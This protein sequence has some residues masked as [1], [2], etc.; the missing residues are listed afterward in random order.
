MVL[1]LP[2][3]FIAQ[4]KQK[5]WLNLKIFVLCCSFKLHTLE[6]QIL[7]ISKTI[8]PKLI[9]HLYLSYK[10]PDSLLQERFMHVKYVKNL[11]VY[12]NFNAFLSKRKTMVS[13]KT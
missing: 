3:R 6:E 7:N 12:N 10:L 13:S 1:K 5:K 8:F 11:C 4:L 2:L 9:F